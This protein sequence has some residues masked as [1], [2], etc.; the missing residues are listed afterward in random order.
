MKLCKILIPGFA[1]VLLF[2]SVPGRGFIFAQSIPNPVLVLV[3]L[4]YRTASGK[5]LTNYK[6]AVENSADFPIELFSPAALPTCGKGQ[7]AS[8]S[9]VDIYDSRGKRL[10]EFCA[11]NKPGDLGSLWFTLESKEVPPIYVYI[12]LLD[13]QTNT[14]YKSNLAETVQ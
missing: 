12:E 6:F 14:K 8:R 9:R 1:I 11:V 10:N 13:T 5:E 4:D 3:G 2:T 7:K